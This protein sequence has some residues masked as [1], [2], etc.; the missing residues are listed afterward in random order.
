MNRFTRTTASA[1][2]LV[3]MAA[4]PAAAMYVEGGDN[5]PAGPGMVKILMAPAEEP[6]YHI[7]PAPADMPQVI[8][9]PV[10]EIM[11][12]SAPLV[13][14]VLATRAEPATILIDSTRITY[15]QKPILVNGTLMVPLRAIV[16]GAGGQ[17]TWDGETQTV[18]ARLGDRTAYFVIG[19]AEAEMNQDNVR[20][21]KR[22]MIKMT[23]APVLEGSRTLV[24]ADALT[25]VLGLMEQPGAAGALNLVP[26]AKFEAPAGEIP[27]AP[28]E[29]QAWI[30][31]GTIKETKAIEGGIRILVAGQAMADGEGSL[32]WFA[33]TGET[34]I[35]I[36]EN[37]VQ[38]PGTYADL[39]TAQKVAVKPVGPML[40]SY[41]AQGGAAA[42]TI[43][44]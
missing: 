5:T 41:P 25:T 20:Y 21:L 16:E 24:A 42:V 12:I 2:L 38:T 11:P 31:V 29:E 27:P 32:I 26:A 39:A 36:E 35:T 9:A 4:A 44:K 28:A 10:G 40:M 19:Q 7:L 22:N 13:R 23:K 1:L 3:M 30:E 6:V 37:G 33:V 8:S 18:T 17:V 43:H 15:D 34:T 14:E